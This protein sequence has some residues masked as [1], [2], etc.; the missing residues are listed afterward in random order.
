MKRG[1][2]V[3]AFVYF[4]GHVVDRTIFRLLACCSPA[5]RDRL[6]YFLCAFSTILIFVDFFFNVDAQSFDGERRSPAESASIS[7]EKSMCDPDGLPTS[8]SEGQTPTTYSTVVDGLTVQ[9]CFGV[10]LGYYSSVE[11]EIATVGR[12]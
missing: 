6:A 11:L 5:L 3:C 1:K 2:S 8:R 7:R 4:F 10:F 12:F 9:G